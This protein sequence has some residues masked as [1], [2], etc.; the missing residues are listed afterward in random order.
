[1]EHIKKLRGRSNLPRT[2]ALWRSAL[3]LV[4][5]FLGCGGVVGSGPSQP[6]P[7]GITLTVAP[8]SASVLLGEPQVF[9]ATVDGTSDTAATWSVNGIPAGN[10]TVGTID[11][12]GQYTAPAN[13]P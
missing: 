11:A 10:S 8:L 13:L 3:I 12:N 5:F 7:S 9:T 4:A 6:P 2:A 1:M